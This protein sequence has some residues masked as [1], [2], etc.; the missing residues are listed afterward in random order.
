VLPQ[1]TVLFNW[2]AFDHFEIN[3]GPPSDRTGSTV[4]WTH[5]NAIDLDAD[6]NLLVSFRN[7][8]EVTKINGVS[9]AVIWRMGG[10]R[11]QFTFVDSP[12]P[13]FG[14]QHSAR[15]SAPNEITLL[16][17]VGTPGESRGERYTIEETTHTAR[18]ARSYGSSPQV[19]TPIG[20]SIQPLPGGRTLVSFGTAG[21]VEE[22]DTSG[23]VM[24][25]I[26]GQPGYVFR[27]QC[28]RSLYRPGFGDA[29]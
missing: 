29:R 20:G 17:N 15:V 2:S 16:D 3:D 25:R 13:A 1:F 28:I 12:S 14:G 6:G 7:L 11:N 5:G 4:N 19:V 22:Y 23:R 10:Q 21:R 9:G 8:S 27:A 26:D 18:L 24:W